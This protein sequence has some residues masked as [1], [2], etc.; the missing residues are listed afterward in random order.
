MARNLKLYGAAYNTDG[1]AEI[2]LTING[3]VG[4]EGPVTTINSTAPEQNTTEVGFCDF[5]LDD[6]FL[7]GGDLMV[8]I[9]AKEGTIFVAGIG[10]AEGEANE[11][12]G[13]NPGQLKTN[14]SYNGGEPYTLTDDDVAGMGVE[15][16]EDGVVGEFHIN[17]VPGATVSFDYELPPKDENL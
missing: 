16:N 10:E 9:T 12:F 7:V 13:S 14:V 6:D 8:N 2:S 17:I 1:D 11:F 4:Y 15:P 3:N 5:A